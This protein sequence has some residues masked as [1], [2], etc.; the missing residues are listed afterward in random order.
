MVFFKDSGEVSTTF[1]VQAHN[2]FTEQLF[3]PHETIKWNDCLRCLTHG[4][5]TLQGQVLREGGGGSRGAEGSRG[6]H[7]SLWWLSWL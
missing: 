5:G 6:L 1:L 7:H 3:E 2:R 4:V